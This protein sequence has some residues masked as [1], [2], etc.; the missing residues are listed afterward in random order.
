MD[1]IPLSA[2]EHEIQYLAMKHGMRKEQIKQIIQQ[3]G[4]RSRKETEDA[5]AK[6]KENA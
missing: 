3:S 6:H 5:I 1:R 2:E 4:S